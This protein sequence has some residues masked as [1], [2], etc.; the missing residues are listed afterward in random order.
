D[1]GDVRQTLILSKSHF[2]QLRD[3]VHARRIA[4]D[5]AYSQK[6]AVREAL[7]LLFATNGIAA[8]RSDQARERERQHRELIRKGRQLRAA[9]ELPPSSGIETILDE[10]QTTTT[11]L[12]TSNL[13]KLKACVR[14]KEYGIIKQMQERY[15]EQRRLSA[16]K[17]RQY[18]SSKLCLFHKIGTHNPNKL[19][20][21]ADTKMADNKVRKQAGRKR[22]RRQSSE[23]LPK[24]SNRPETVGVRFS[25]AENEELLAQA[26]RQHS[27]MDSQMGTILRNA[28]LGKEPTT[29]PM[30]EVLGPAAPPQIMSTAALADYQQ[31]VAV[32]IK[33]NNMKEL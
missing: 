25:K 1:A 4:G 14:V 30:P 21:Q 8:P 26:K 7:D 2:E 17:Q 3:L 10:A 28:W 6:Q 19:C 12:S 22:K 31:V 16:K 18:L 24:G 13:T 33:L 15:E 5:Y 23:Q 11:R 20:Q 9:K 27:Q 32:A 29:V